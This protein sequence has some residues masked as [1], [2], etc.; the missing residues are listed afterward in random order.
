MVF[1][2]WLDGEMDAVLF[3]RDFARGTV[4]VSSVVPKSYELG[5]SIYTFVGWSTELQPAYS[6]AVYTARYSARLKTEGME[7]LLDYLN[8]SA[9]KIIREGQL[10]ILLNGKM[11]NALGGEVTNP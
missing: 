6:D 5:D 1:R 9:S 10:I 11:Y 7:N 3:E 4:P 8:P 2:G